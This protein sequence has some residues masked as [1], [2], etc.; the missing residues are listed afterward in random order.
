M[1]KQIDSITISIQGKENIE[2]VQDVMMDWTAEKYG[3]LLE[4]LNNEKLPI[5]LFKLLE[6]DVFQE[7]FGK[8][9]Q[10]LEHL[11][12]KLF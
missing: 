5:I 7:T 3:Q 10:E 4:A 9:K 2:E 1:P 11:K 8:T 6:E 12:I